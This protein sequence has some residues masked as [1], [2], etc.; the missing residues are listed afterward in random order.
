[1]LVN[2]NAHFEGAAAGELFNGEGKTDILIRVED[3][4]VFIGECKIW[5]GVTSL[6]QALNQIFRYLVWRDTKAAILLF[7]R[8]RDVTA[9]IAK[10]IA[11]IEQHPHH[12]RRGPES[13]D[14]QIDFVM[15]ATGDP[16]REIH[17][18]LLPFALPGP[19]GN[20]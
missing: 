17:L 10:A 19:A 14:D 16:Q 2:L 15:H 13:N 8:N 9:V 1:L 11:A 20:R 18:A 12:K 5:D 3:R 7:I 4:N 6:Q